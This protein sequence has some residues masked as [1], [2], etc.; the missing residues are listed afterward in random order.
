ASFC[1]CNSCGT[2][3]KCP[4]CSIN[5]VY[6]FAGKTLDCHYCNYSIPLP[7]LCPSCNSGYIRLEGA[8][9]EKIESELSRIFPQA[10]ISLLGA[11]DGD[12]ADILIA[13]ESVLKREYGP[14]EAVIVYSVDNLLNRIDFRATERVYYLLSALSRT[15]KVLALS[16]RI[17][18]H[19]A[20]T[21]LVN[22]DSDYFY[23]EELKQREQVKFPPFRHFAL[24]RVRGR[25]ES[26]VK[27]AACGL[28]SS[29]REA[30]PEGRGFEAISAGPAHPPRLRGNFYWQ[31]LFAAK[32]PVA[33]SRW[34]KM[35][36]KKCRHSGIIVTVDIDPQ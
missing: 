26:R 27:E 3:L 8:G 13:T 25:Q 19:Y 22:K 4:R 7:D 35:N 30:M 12:N 21:S 9:A 23:T 16:T 34:L 2:V 28:F 10:R 18:G 17:P 36:L 31:V 1:A 6:H 15:A 11:E 14:F 29:L 20:F 32:N 24:L 5:L 33:L